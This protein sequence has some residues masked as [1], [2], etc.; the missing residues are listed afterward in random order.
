[1]KQK[2]NPYLLGIILSGG[3]NLLG[4]GASLVTI[5]VGARLLSQEELGAF[6]LVMLVAQFTALFGDIGLQNTAIKTLSSLPVD[7]QEFIQT[8][9]FLLSITLATSLVACLFLSLILPLLQS[10][11]PYQHFQDN[12]FYIAPVAFLT[13]GMQV[14]MSLLIGAKQ[15][16]QLSLLSAAIE[17]LR[18]LLS[19]GGLLAGLGISS[20]FWGMIASRVIGIGALWISMP[21][22]F[23]IALRHPQS[24]DLLK[25]GGW[26]YG[27]SLV[28][29][30]MVR[31]S[32]TILTTYM[33]TASLAIYSAAMQIPSVLQRLFESIRP[34]L[35]GYISG[36]NATYANPQIT[37]IRMMTALLAVAATFLITLAKPLMTMLYSEKYETGII[38]MQTLSVWAAFTIINYL[39]S[40]ILI[41]NGHSRKAF[42]LTLPQLLIILATTGV[43]VPRYEGL[44]A[45][46]ALVITAFLGNIIG[47]WLVAGDNRSIYLALTTGFFRAAVPLL[48]LLI[49]ASSM[50]ASFLLL[51]G[52]A[53]VT[54]LLLGIFKAVTLEDLKALREILTGLARRAPAPFSSV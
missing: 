6:F 33:G 53:C 48:L 40:I 35:L 26:L 12:V 25:S 20:L 16:R 9:R 4:M 31:A 49:A 34:A 54:I 11:W 27:C 23:G 3:A 10:L 14:M 44:G 19:V 41:G 7:S 17:I 51:C 18:A 32:D 2:T 52:F 21:S 5:M 37:L 8:S 45:A 42:M 1:M 39:Y 38:I 28:S 46:I 30:I 36:Q 13:T 24:A 22:I 50:T 43:L 15:F 29:V 47:A